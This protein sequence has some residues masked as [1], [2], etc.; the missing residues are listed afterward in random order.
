[1]NTDPWPYAPS[2]DDLQFDAR[3]RD[4]EQCSRCGQGLPNCHRPPPPKPED[5]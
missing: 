3:T 1:M 5:P 2:R 4:A